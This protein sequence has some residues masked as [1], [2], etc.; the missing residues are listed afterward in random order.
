M[1]EVGSETPH[2]DPGLYPTM[3]NR[4]NQGR[5]GTPSRAEHRS[6]RRTSRRASSSTPILQA[7]RAR[8]ALPVRAKSQ[9]LPGHSPSAPGA[10]CG[11]QPDQSPTG[12]VRPVS[13]WS[14]ASA[15]GRGAGGGRGG[16]R[17]AGGSCAGVP[18]RLS[19]H[20]A[21]TSRHGPRDLASERTWRHPIRGYDSAK[22]WL[23]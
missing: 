9:I 3:M 7:Q 2:P 13:A 17:R 16:A 6:T 4:M 19:R 5:A 1:I 12:R 8:N 21:R 20:C 23:R 18:C 14:L 15:K 10:V 22:L 11:Q